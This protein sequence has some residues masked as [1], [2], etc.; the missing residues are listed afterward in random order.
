M[1][2]IEA[3]FLFAC[4]AAAMYLAFKF[5]QVANQIESL[6]KELALSHKEKQELRADL[7]KTREALAKCESGEHG[8]G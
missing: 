7:Q 8:S 1:I 3:A 6:R 4:G 5:W 2:S